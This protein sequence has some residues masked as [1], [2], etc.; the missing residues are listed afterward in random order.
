MTRYCVNATVAVDAWTF[1]EADDA[2]AALE[3]AGHLRESDFELGDPVHVEI[4]GVEEDE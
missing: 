2:E 3:H 4:I 1:L